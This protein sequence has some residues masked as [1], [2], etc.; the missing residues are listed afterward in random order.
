M[1][2]LMLKIIILASCVFFVSV[3]IAFAQFISYKFDFNGDGTFDGN[4]YLENVGDTLN[5]DIWLDNYDCP[6]SDELLGAQL[7]F[8][9]DP[10]VLQVVDAYP[11]DGDHGGHLLLRSVVLYKKKQGFIF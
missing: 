5:V 11:N 9:Y 1:K 3:S 4:W 8:G 7:Y 6:P 2:T 10:A